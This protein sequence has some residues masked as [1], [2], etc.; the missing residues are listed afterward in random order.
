MLYKIKELF[1]LIFS[2]KISSETLYKY[3]FS[4]YIFDNL[5]YGSG[6]GHQL[7]LWQQKMI[8]R[9]PMNLIE[10][11]RVRSQRKYARGVF[12]S[13]RQTLHKQKCQIWPP[14][15]QLASNGI[16]SQFAYKKKK[17][18]FAQS[19]SKGTKW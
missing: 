1:N 9:Q 13:K 4:K 3:S 6:K 10:Y 12:T 19:Q 2:N 11:M 7:I 15:S 17:K 8:T 5:I 16:L 18:D 14:M